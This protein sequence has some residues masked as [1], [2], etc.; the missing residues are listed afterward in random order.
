MYI[1][2][3]IHTKT[4]FSRM[5]SATNW[6]FH[7]CCFIDRS[8]EPTAN[9]PESTKRRTCVISWV[10]MCVIRLWRCGT[11]NLAVVSHS[12][13]IA[14]DDLWYVPLYIFA[15]TR[16]LGS[17]CIDHRVGK[18]SVLSVTDYGVLTNSSYGTSSFFSRPCILMATSYEKPPG[19]GCSGR[20]STD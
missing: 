18:Y 8:K 12:P 1:L 7:F 19:A 13:L 6:V 10:R 17:S 14:I 5:S 20:V 3:Y 4:S 9:Q 2:K 15:L 16:Y 11:W